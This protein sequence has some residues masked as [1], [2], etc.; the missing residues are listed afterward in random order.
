MASA[1]AVTADSFVPLAGSSNLFEIESSR[2]AM[3]RSQS[4][5]VKQFANQMVADHTL[6][7]SKMKAALSEAKIPPPPEKLNVKDQKVY[8]SLKQAQGAAFDKAYIEAQYNAHV[9]AV[10]L[11][12][13]YAKGGDNPRLKALAGELLPTLQGHLD[14]VSKLRSS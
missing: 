4:A 8:D 3:Q 9:E 1:A 14:H 6:A 11:F 10:N 7:V 5:Q 13:A 12:S 2:L